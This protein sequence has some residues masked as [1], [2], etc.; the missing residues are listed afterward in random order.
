MS[1]DVLIILLVLGLIANILLVA[2]VAWINYRARRAAA[3]PDA[4][5][6]LAAHEADPG[7]RPGTGTASP[8][9][10]P[11][12]SLPDAAIE[13]PSAPPTAVAEAPRRPAARRTPREPTTHASGDAGPAA[14]RSRRF[15]LPDDDGSH[16]RTDRAIAAFL[17]EPVAPDPDARSSRRRHRA[18]RPAGAPV[19]RTDLVLSLAGADPDPRLVHALSAAMRSTVRSSDEVV[20]LPGGRLRITLEADVPGGEAFVRRA[21][22]VVKPWLSALDPDLQLRVDRPRTRQGASSPS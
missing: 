3:L 13:T 20:E 12:V 18:R 15:V 5:A 8:R 16:A 4:G 17:G 14:R 11:A 2:G 9:D 19:P 21:R 1:R 22:S 6:A 10:A 7:G